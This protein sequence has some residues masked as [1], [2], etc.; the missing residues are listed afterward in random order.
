MGLVVIVIQDEDEDNVDVKTFFEPP[1]NIE[2][3]DSPTSHH[4]A[5]DMLTAAMGKAEEVK[6]P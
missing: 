5:V 4:V 1:L 3:D 2:N 6:I